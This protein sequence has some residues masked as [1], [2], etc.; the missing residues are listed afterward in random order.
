MLAT[1]ELTALQIPS[2]PMNG[3][4]EEVTTSPQVIAA[5]LDQIPSSGL[6]SPEEKDTQVTCDVLCS[7][8]VAYPQQPTLAVTAT[9]ETPAVNNTMPTPEKRKSKTCPKQLQLPMFLS[10]KSP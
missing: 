9:A 1:T 5:E 3:V 2:H 8:S 7:L 6:L 10:S 4:N